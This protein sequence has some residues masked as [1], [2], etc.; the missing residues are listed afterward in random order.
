MSVPRIVGHTHFVSLPNLT[1][2]VL[3][4]IA[5]RR[6]HVIVHLYNDSASSISGE[7][8]SVCRFEI[9]AVYT[10]FVVGWV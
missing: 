4:P 2:A 3:K 7:L 5:L 10:A 9:F 8:K 1:R 6:S